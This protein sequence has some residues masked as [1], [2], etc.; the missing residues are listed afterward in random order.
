MKAAERTCRISW[1]LILFLTALS[2]TGGH[3]ADVPPLKLIQTV[4]LPGVKGRFD[5]FSVDVT[6]NRLFVAALGNNTVEV[7]DLVAGKRL[8]SITGMSKP[9][10]V[11]FLPGR[12]ELLVANGDDGTVKVLDG[13]DFTLKQNIPS[14]PDADNVRL[15]PN[16]GLA[17]VGYGDGTLVGISCSELKPKATIK[18]PGHPES[19]QFEK[20]GSRVFVNVP[21]ARRIVVVD[22]TKAQTLVQWPM[23]KFQANFP[24]ALDGLNHRLFVGCRK[25]SR[26]VVFDTGLGKQIGDFSISGDTDDLFYDA[27]RKRLYI[28]CGEG[29][30]DVISQ[31]SPD[32]YKTLAKVPTSPGARTCFLSPEL[33]RLCLAVPARGGHD[34]EI[35]IYQPE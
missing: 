3:S 20:P 34:A 35:R 11:L 19:F 33:D 12:S 28:S 15:D 21:D 13:T 29:S 16:S 10:G 9:Q 14:L 7:I 1:A 25:P 6:G 17:W 23:D 31:E 30:M 27:K 2:V 5:H 26:L 18:L 24:M 8:H 4:P 32:D 22:A